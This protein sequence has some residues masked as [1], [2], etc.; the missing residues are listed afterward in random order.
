MVDDI[1]SG[2]EVEKD[3]VSDAVGLEERME[4]GG[5]STRQVVT[6]ES[7]LHRL[8]LSLARSIKSTEE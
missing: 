3:D 6:T 5:I 4:D 1:E 7:S 2:L 8:Y